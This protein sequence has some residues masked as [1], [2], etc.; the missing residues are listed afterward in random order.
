MSL[1]GFFHSRRLTG[2]HVQDTNLSPDIAFGFSTGI[3][4]SRTWA[5]SGGLGVSKSYSLFHV[6]PHAHVARKLASAVRLPVLLTKVG[7]TLLSP[8]SLG[9]HDRPEIFIYWGKMVPTYFCA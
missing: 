9:I 1:A 2:F 6:A 5:E 8:P 3:D 7:K 4:L